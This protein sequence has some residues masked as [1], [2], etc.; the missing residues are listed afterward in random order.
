MSLRLWE[1]VWRI[2]PIQDG[3]FRGCS[4]MG[5]T[6]VPSSLKSYLTIMKPGTVIPYLKKIQQIYQSRDTPLEF[7]WH[8]RFTGNQQ[9][10][11]IK[12]YWYM[13][14]FHTWFL[15]FLNF[16]WALKGCFNKNGCN[17]DDVSKI[18]TKVFWNK[19]YDVNISVHGVTTKILSRD[20]NYIVDVVMWPKFGNSSI[21][22]WEVFINSILY[23]QK[24]YLFWGVT[25]F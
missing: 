21:S 14:H 22:M 8:Q 20:S 3:P 2:N 16:F 24:K 9:L 25:L 13:L 4:P 7:C 11:Y 23:D 12:K 5:M 1:L 17:I 6:N 15:I 19:G 18:K 10:F